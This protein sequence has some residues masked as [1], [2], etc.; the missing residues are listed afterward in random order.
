MLPVCW[1]EVGM[2]PAIST[3]V[4]LVFLRLQ[5]NAVIVPKFHIVTGRFSCRPPDIGSDGV[6]RD[7]TIETV[8]SA[9]SVP[10]LYGKPWRLFK[11]IFVSQS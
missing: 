2:H 7:V 9:W 5:A 8:F 1:I 3:K 6:V 4:L 10:I 11:V